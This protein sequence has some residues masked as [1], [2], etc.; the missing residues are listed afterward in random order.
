[1]QYPQVRFY[2]R[3]QPYRDLLLGGLQSHAHLPREPKPMRDDL[4][5]CLALA[6]PVATRANQIELLQPLECQRIACDQRDPSC[7]ANDRT[8]Q[9]LQQALADLLGCQAR[10]LPPKRCP[11]AQLFQYERKRLPIPN[12]NEP[13]A[14]HTYPPDPSLET[15]LWSLRPATARRYFEPAKQPFRWPKWEA[16]RPI[17]LAMN[18]MHCD[19]TD[20]LPK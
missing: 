4:G 2:L 11:L 18:P 8:D 6:Q 20:Q 19:P 17:L 12:S 7:L 13:D 16:H 3:L 5:P 9:A 1:M 15:C 10:L 14:A